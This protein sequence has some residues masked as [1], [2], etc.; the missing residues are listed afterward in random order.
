MELLEHNRINDHPI[1][2]LDNKQSPYYLIYSLGP[3]EL[4]MLKTYIEAKLASNF[5]RQSRSHSGAPI[6]FIQKIDSMSTCT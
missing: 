6:L 5:I 1:N 3:V 4:A 2:L